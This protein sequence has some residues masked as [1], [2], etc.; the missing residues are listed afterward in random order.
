MT[1]NTELLISLARYATIMV[2]IVVLGTT[3]VG[4]IAFWKTQKG[5]ATTF[6]LLLQRASALQMLTVILIVVAACALR[7]IDAI[8]SEA[9]ISLLSG[10][11]GFV[12]GNIGKV[13]QG[14]EERPE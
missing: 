14:E 8:N 4:S 3:I 2:A 10:V 13:K 1:G 9:V 11:A 6:S 5:A 12:L 7:L